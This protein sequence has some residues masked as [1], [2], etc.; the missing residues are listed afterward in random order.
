M[1]TQGNT[2][3]S[4]NNL[5]KHFYLK[6][7]TV[8]KPKKDVV[9][10]VNNVSFEIKSG[11]TYGLVGESGSGKSTIGRTLLRALEPTSGEVIF[12]GVD[13]T[14]LS[15]SELNKLRLEMQMVFQDPYSALNP[16]MRIGPAIQEALEIHNIGDKQSRKERVIEL[17]TQV[18]LQPEYYNRF[19]RE[20]SGGQRQRIVI[21][22]ALALNPKLVVC[23]EPVSALDL[24]IQS[25][26]INLFKDLQKQFK[27]SYLFISHNLSVIRY[28]SD[29]VGVLY[30]G[31]LVEE[32]EVDRLFSNP[33]HPY[34]RALLSSI[35]KDKPRDM[36]ER[37]LLEGDIP[38]PIDLPP[39]C[40]FH[41]RC[42]SAMS[43][44]K[45]VTPQRIDMD[46][47][48]WVACHLYG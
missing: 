41:T 40:S 36:K 7:G 13:I 45:E 35:P 5:Y 34:T 25:Q 46:K 20:F 27:L 43:I 10:A 1:N 4:V 28:I 17:L 11:E 33:L 9:K 16:R 23:D 29:R 39:G 26:I 31:Q 15:R 30:L 48:H 37:I 38:S 24:S 12:K 18:G 44:C 21:A 47:D 8:L 19:P 3:V 2:L 42:K 14:R 6:G 32:A 22:R